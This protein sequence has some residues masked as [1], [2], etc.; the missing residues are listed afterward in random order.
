MD[1]AGALL[2]RQM[3]WSDTVL[4]DEARPPGLDQSRSG[5]QEVS[6][7]LIVLSET[8]DPRQRAKHLQ[9]QHQTCF[10]SHEPAAATR[11]CCRRSRSHIGAAR[12]HAAPQ[13]SFI[14]T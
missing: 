12:S 4:S 2:V 8:H 1:E 13:C 9:A 5:S 14:N 6:E 10:S 7:S 3:M 11:G